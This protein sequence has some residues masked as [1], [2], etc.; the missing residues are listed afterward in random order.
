MKTKC[1]INLF[2]CNL[3]HKSQYHPLSKIKTFF[4]MVVTNNINSTL[5]PNGTIDLQLEKST[6]RHTRGM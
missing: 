3:F 1:E 2:I 6:A 4:S 5:L